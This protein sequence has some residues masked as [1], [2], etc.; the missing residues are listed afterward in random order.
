MN[1]FSGPLFLEGDVWGLLLLLL[2]VGQLKLVGNVLL[3]IQ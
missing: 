2:N 3:G 1:K